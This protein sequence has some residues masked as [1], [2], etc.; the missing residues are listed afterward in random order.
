MQF[1]FL[2]TVSWKNFLA[3]YSWGNMVVGYSIPEEH[4]FLVVDERVAFGSAVEV[5]TDVFAERVM[6][7]QA[8]ALV[9]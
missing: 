1:D 3:C 7:L 6:I 4:T 2:V 8:V 5:G 9:E